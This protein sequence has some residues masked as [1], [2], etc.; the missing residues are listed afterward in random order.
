MQRSPSGEAGT[1]RGGQLRRLTPWGAG[2]TVDRLQAAHTPGRG[3]L[4]GP[5]GSAGWAGSGGERS[6]TQ[7]CIW[8]R[9]QGQILGAPRGTAQGTAETRTRPP[10]PGLCWGHSRGPW[11]H[12]AQLWA[13]LGPGR[14]GSLSSCAGRE[15]AW[16]GRRA[17]CGPLCPAGRGQAWDAQP[18]NL[19]VVSL[20]SAPGLPFSAPGP[21]WRVQSWRPWGPSVSLRGARSGSWP[22]FGWCAWRA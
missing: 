11:G 17:W 7:S 5:P 6:R 18:G 13:G 20:V 8:L 10:A 9:A 15:R 16:T 12:G 2:P 22:G 4:S 1:R 21:Q 14:L 3:A 19:G